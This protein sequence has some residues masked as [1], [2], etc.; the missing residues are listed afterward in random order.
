[1]GWLFVVNLPV[2]KP[3]GLTRLL[4]LLT[5]M[6]SVNF[7]ETM[8]IVDAVYVCVALALYVNMNAFLW[9]YVAELSKNLNRFNSAVFLRLS[10]TTRL[11]LIAE[12]SAG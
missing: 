5:I 11:D 3:A 2:Y 1:M 7:P 6:F 10:I 12:K 4:P 9:L 8:G